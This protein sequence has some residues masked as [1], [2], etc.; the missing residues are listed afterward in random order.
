MTFSN[1]NLPGV[2]LMVPRVF[3][4]A[5]GYLFESYK[6]Q[7]FDTAV[8]RQIE[9]VQENEFVE[10]QGFEKKIPGDGQNLI[11]RCTAGEILDMVEDRRES[12]P[13]YGVS[14]AETLSGENYH[15]LYVPAGC[16]LSFR[17]VSPNALISVKSDK[18]HPLSD[19]H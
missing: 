9:F 15:Q 3:N 1:T 5:R 14:I 2:L 7:E 18:Y 19:I 13:E 6:Q 16:A 10:H 12:S 17:V 4:D 8:G 11:I